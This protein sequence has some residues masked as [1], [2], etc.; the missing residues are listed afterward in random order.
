MINNELE[1]LINAALIDNEIS[2]KEKEILIKKAQSLGISREELESY[3]NEKMKNSGAANT[4]SKRGSVKHCPNCGT[5]MNSFQV[6]CPKCGYMVDD[7]EANRS[8]KELSDAI[9]AA[10]TLEERKLVIKTF[11]VPNTKATLLELLTFL[12]PKAEDRNDPCYE[13]YYQKYQECVEKSKV[14]FGNDEDFKSFFLEQSNVQKGKKTYNRIEWIT[15]HYKGLLI[16]L[17]VLAI[18]VAVS[19]LIHKNNVKNRKIEQENEMAREEQ[20]IEKD[21]E[22]QLDSLYLEEVSNDLKDDD[23]S[24]AIERLLNYKGPFKRIKGEYIRVLRKSIYDN[25]D[26]EAKKM[27]LSYLEKDSSFSEIKFDYEEV[28]SRFINAKDYESAAELIYPYPQRY[29][30]ISDKYEETVAA[31]LNEQNTITTAK[32]LYLKWEKEP[33]LFYQHYLNNGDYE[34][35]KEYYI[36][37]KGDTEEA[38]FQYL[39]ECVTDMSKKGD[40]DGAEKFIENN[41]KHFKK[42]TPFSERLSQ[43]EV[44]KKL[45]TIIKEHKK[46]QKKGLFGRKKDNK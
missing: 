2:P 39:V 13:A 26:I 36:K 42:H 38:L 37:Y 23:I 29:E 12:K 28:L 33:R 45:R 30:D 19:V 7:A 31:L 14:S 34:S 46:N 17:G 9:R 44:S 35:A 32:R 8:V 6:Q 20:R 18:V 27:L 1:E 25:H 3:L 21:K 43:R 41:L 40:Y 24:K 22:R 4:S 11:P 15:A 10:Q 16:A 5:V